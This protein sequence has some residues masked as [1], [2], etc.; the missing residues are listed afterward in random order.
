MVIVWGLSCFSGAALAYDMIECGRVHK[1][2]MFLREID[3]AKIFLICGKI[4]SGKTT[5]AK[6]LIKTIPA[7]LLSND[8]ITYILFGSHGGKEHGVVSER[9]QRY[10]FQK[11]LEIIES[12]I[13]VVLEWGFITRA[14]RLE[15]SEFYKQNNIE[16][17]WHYIDTPDDVL[18]ERLGKRNQD[19]ADGKST[20]HYFDYDFAKQFRRV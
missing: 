1:K 19:I 8:E 12:G 4:C 7:V 3:M 6:S 16:Y 10:L 14:E 17:E 20:A 15:V 5:Y 11:S 13:N 2:F 9:T 18:L